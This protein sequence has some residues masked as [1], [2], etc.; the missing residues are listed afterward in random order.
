MDARQNLI[1]LPGL[2]CDG[3][4]WRD[5]ISGLADLA[6]MTVADL[7]QAAT[8]EA[9]AAAVLAAAPDRFALA[10][11]SMGGYVAFEIL[12]QAPRR[13]TR[14][15]LLDT[16][17]RSDGPAQRATREAQ[18]ARARSGAF[19]DIVDELIPAL[20]HP[21]RLGDDDAAGVYR[22]MALSLGPDV[23]LRQQAAIMDRP[24]S[25]TRLGEIRC[26]T[27]V[28]CGRQ[29]QRAPVE[30]HREMADAIP[31]ARLAVIED[32]GHLA[33]VERP[34]EVTREMRAWLRARDGTG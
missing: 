24:D 18:M 21:A 32:C 28:L 12:R 1:L 29:D 26:P 7:S 34:A 10:G 13:V 15:A 25:R 22:A 14:L 17:A 19:R 30:V 20:V 3:R 9:M 31:G 4:L 2:L 27:L 5:Q 11:L 33:T 6:D 16:S 8:M 23:F